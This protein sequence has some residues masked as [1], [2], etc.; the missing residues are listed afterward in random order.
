[1]LYECQDTLIY[2]FERSQHPCDHGKCPTNLYIE[3]S[4][5]EKPPPKYTMYMYMYI[6]HILIDPSWIFMSS[7][8]HYRHLG[9]YGDERSLALIACTHSL[10]NKFIRVITKPWIATLQHH[11]YTYISIYLRI[12]IYIYASYVHF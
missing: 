4:S 12:Y 10:A 11:I 2:I 3:T 8:T 5:P 1:M 7:G 9:I 6:T